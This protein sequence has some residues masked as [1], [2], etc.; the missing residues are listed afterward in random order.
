M[1][2][3]SRRADHDTAPARRSL[4]IAALSVAAATTLGGSVFAAS[5]VANASSPGPNYSH[6]TTTQSAQPMADPSPECNG[7]EGFCWDYRDWYW[8]YSN[9]EDA[10]QAAINGSQYIDYVCTTHGLVVWLW[11]ERYAA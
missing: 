10:G 9:C 6:V 2:V 1:H 7:K 11:L 5:G 4:R 3:R 8:T